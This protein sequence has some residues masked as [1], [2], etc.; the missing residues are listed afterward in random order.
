[1]ARLSFIFLAF[2]FVGLRG[3]AKENF[4]ISTPVG[5]REVGINKVLCLNNGYTLLLHFEIS[6][7]VNVQVFDAGHKRIVNNQLSTRLLDVSSFS[8]TIFKGLFELNNEAVLFFEQQNVGRHSLIRLRIDPIKGKLLDET[9]VAK[10]KSV[11]KPAE[12]LVMRNKALSGYAV[13]VAQDV[14]QFKESEVHVTYYN[15]RHEP[16][17]TV[18][19]LFDRG[20]YDYLSVIG[21]ESLPEGECISLRLSNMVVNGTGTS[22]ESSARYNHYLQVFVIPRDSTAPRARLYDLSTDV[23]PHYVTASH[24]SFAGNFNL[25]LLNFREAFVRYGI[26]MRPVAI[27]SDLFFSLSDN[28]PEGKYKWI[29]H[30]LANSLLKEKADSG[31]NFSGLPVCMFT[32]ENGLTTIVS[33]SYERYISADGYSRYQSFSPYLSGFRTTQL[34]DP[35]NPLWQTPNTST[36]YN[37]F[38]AADNYNRTQSFETFLGN[39]CITQVD[40]DGNEIWGAVLPKSQYYRSYKHY[41]RPSDVGRR[42]QSQAMFN[43]IPPQIFERQFLSASVHNANGNLYIIYNDC[44]KNINNSIADPGDT[45]YSSELANACFYKVDKQHNI[46]KSYLLGEPLI[47]EYKSIFVE[48]ADFDQE[49]TTYA[50]LIRYKRG[51]YVTLRMAWVKL[52]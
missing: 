5:L 7:P 13:L 23:Q 30:K 10:W 40:D 33:E 25:L 45:V 37:K 38:I 8:T 22:T 11:A 28:G 47:K 39:L 32:N 16:I 49:R 21:A 41:Y 42:W 50:T 52:D 51:E 44:G 15:A 34:D 1:M 48:G 43:D 4:E 29:T 14:P 6:K 3:S 2:M 19:L 46:T 27:Q 26:E 9:T 31:K 18:P 12:F 24:N 17:R 35:S 20:K 36:Q